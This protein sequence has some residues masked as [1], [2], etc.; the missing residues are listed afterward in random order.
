MTSFRRLK[1]ICV[2]LGGLYL[3]TLFVYCLAQYQP[4]Q[5]YGGAVNHPDAEQL[6]LAS[7][8]DTPQSYK[9]IRITNNDEFDLTYP[10]IAAYVEKPELALTVDDLVVDED[11]YPGAAY[12]LWADWDT[13]RLSREPAPVRA[14]AHVAIERYVQ[15]LGLGDTTT[16]AM[17][18][19]FS[20]KKHQLQGKVP[21]SPK[22]ADE[23]NN[24]YASAAMVV[25]MSLCKNVTNLY[26]GGVGQQTP[27][28]DYLLKNN[29]GLL[30]QQGLQ[31]VKQIEIIPLAPRMWDER[32]YEDLEFLDY[33]RYF[34]RLPSLEM[35]TMDGLAEYQANR[36]LFPPGTANLKKLRIGH[37]DISSELLSTIIRAP[38]ALEEFT[39]IEGGLWS[40][41]G[42]SPI[43][44][45]K[46]IGKSLLDHK[47]TLKVLDLDIGRGLPYTASGAPEHLGYEGEDE[48]REESVYLGGRWEDSYAHEKDTYFNMDEAASQGP[49]FARDIPDTR[50]YGYTIGSF[51][52]F[53][54]LT[55][56]SINFRLL[57]GPAKDWEPPRHLAG[58][59]PFRL[60]AALPTTLEYFCLYN[61]EKG[62]NVDI[63]DQLTEFMEKKADRLPK[64]KVVKGVDQMFESEGSRWTEDDHEDNLWQRPEVD[65]G[66][67]EV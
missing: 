2:A 55:Q 57:F 53:T 28:Q 54:A 3:N 34:H 6:R 32:T 18:D 47:D 56:M 41:D 36:E 25:L 64:L 63:D 58:Q 52:D 27:L 26:I 42:G 20:W 62:E 17:L 59:P 16:G 30:S 19:A 65:L 10:L 23:H 38:R 9:R 15:S 1:P 22:R 14:D 39:V 4:I 29:Y 43:T 67:I 44:Y 31:R 13:P 21:D 35:V 66:W 7:A 49:L 24:E 51:H 11:A 60:I 48:G 45:P 40:V 37:T 8:W 5:S 50:E 33:F 12:V 46:T 61:Y